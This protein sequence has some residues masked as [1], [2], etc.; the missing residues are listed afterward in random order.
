M[1]TVDKCTLY[2]LVLLYLLLLWIAV[3]VTRLA[4]FPLPLNIYISAEEK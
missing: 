3:G 4:W 1:K 2:M